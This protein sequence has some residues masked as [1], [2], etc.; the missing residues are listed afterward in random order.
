LVFRANRLCRY[1][2]S[3]V[4]AMCGGKRKCLRNA[5]AMPQCSKALHS[6]GSVRTCICM[7]PDVHDCKR[8]G[9]NCELC[10]VYSASAPRVFSRPEKRDSQKRRS[11]ARAYIKRGKFCQL[12][13]G[14]RKTDYPLYVILM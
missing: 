2:S 10:A 3:I 8:C 4:L 5:N 11:R 12:L 1:Q 9:A 7:A 6:D 13:I 14:Y